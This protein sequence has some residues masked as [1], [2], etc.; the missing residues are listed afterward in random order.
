MSDPYSDELN[1][2]N[3]SGWKVRRL[4]PS[5]MTKHQ[6]RRYIREV[7][8]GRS[9]SKESKCPLCGKENVPMTRDHIVPKWILRNVPARRIGVNMHMDGP[10]NIQLICRECNAKKG[11]S[12]DVSTPA[13]MTY[14]TALRNAI[15]RAVYAEK[16]RKQNT[17]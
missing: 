8:Q 12:I 5:R 1:S 4:V 10:E 16:K 13:G 9:P 11:G 6:K 14:W 15:N 2:F 7:V 3:T 17:D